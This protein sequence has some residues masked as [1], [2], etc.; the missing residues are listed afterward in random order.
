MKIMQQA[1]KINSFSTFSNITIIL[2]LTASFAAAQ[3]QEQPLG[4]LKIEGSH[5]EQLMLRASNGQTKTF[6]NPEDTIKL[7]TGTYYLQQVI[8]KNGFLC[9]MGIERIEVFGDKPAVLKV[10]APLKQTVDVKRQGRFLILNYKLTGLGGE[11]YRDQSRKEKPAFTVYKDD[12][13]IA[14]GGFEFG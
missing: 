6:D 9:N 3:A 8:L 11:S 12:K 13:V 7:P 1:Q 2:M 14:S 4:Q 10:G 5:I